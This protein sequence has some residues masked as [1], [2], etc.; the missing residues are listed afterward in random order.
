VEHADCSFPKDVSNIDIN[1]TSMRRKETVIY[2]H[3]LKKAAADSGRSQRGG[4]GVEK[5]G[6][7]QEKKQATSKKEHDESR[8]VSEEI[9]EDSLQ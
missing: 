7:H 1:K 4:K 2:Q 5:E 6:C 3:K 9:L 8:P